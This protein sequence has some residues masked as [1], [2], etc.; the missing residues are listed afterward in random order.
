MTRTTHIEERVAHRRAL[1]GLESG[2]AR[3]VGRVLIV[4]DE[5]DMAELM[6]YHAMKGGYEATLA[7]R[8]IDGIR[9]AKE[10][11]P[12]L[13]SRHHGSGA[14]RLGDLPAAQT[15]SRDGRNPRSHGDRRRRGGRQGARPRDGSR[16]LHYETIFS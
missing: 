2:P 10:F 15:G 7:S 4:E 11:R 1:S 13:A 14:E 16:R 5:R 6:R 8:G 12:N 9:L 3:S